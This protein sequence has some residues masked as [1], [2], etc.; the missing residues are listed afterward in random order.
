MPF[1]GHIFERLYLHSIKMKLQ[2]EILIFAQ[3]IKEVVLIFLVFKI[4]LNASS[5]N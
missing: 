2:F 1:F 5:A 3:T 4:K